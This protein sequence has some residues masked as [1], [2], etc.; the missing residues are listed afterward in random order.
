MAY[1]GL[2]AEEYDRKY[3]DRKL[4]KR[5]SKYFSPYRRSLIIV[6]IFLT[7]YSLSDSFVPILTRQAI[8][9][10]ET[11]LSITYLIFVLGLIFIINFLNWVFNYYRQIHAAK[12][13]GGVVLDLRRD[14]TSAVLNQDLSFFD[15]TPTG[16]IVSRINSDGQDFA[17][18]ADLTIEL[19]SSIIVLGFLITFMFSINIFLTLIFISS[20]PIFFIVALLFRKLARQK[21]LKGQRALANVNSY[22]KESISGI[23][24]A[25]TFRR[26]RKLYDRFNDVNQT[27][28]KVNLKR[29]WVLNTIFPTLGIVSGVIITL[30]IYFGGNGV[31]FG[32]IKG[33]DL[34][35][36]IQSIWLLRFPIFIISSFWPAFQAGLAAAERSFSLIDADP[37][38]IQEDDLK[39]SELRGKIEIKNLTFQYEKDKEV[40]KDFSL[41]VDPGE[42]VALVGH[43][44]AGKSSIA[45]LIARFYEFQN[46][47]I[48]IDNIDIRKFNLREYRKN[49]GI[50][51]QTPFLWADSIEKNIKYSRLTASREDVVEVLEKAGGFDWIEDL[52]EGLD[53]NIR[54]RGSLLSMGQRQLV[55]FARVLLEN[56]SILILDEAT[57]SVDPFTETRIQEAIEKIMENRTSIIIAHRLWTVRHVDRIIVLDHGKI[58]EEGSHDILMQKGGKYAELYKTYFRHQSIEYIDE[59]GRLET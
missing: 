40:F 54:E 53:T 56:P 14:A 2:D 43:T 41:S 29:A 10:I 9:N 11:N 4:L 23:Q 44:G 15:N 1:V 48:L 22:V 36:F 34:F 39:P 16:K 30:I 57:A 25:K 52:P 24:I 8:N 12:V 37:K 20:I 18:T 31:F 21:T 46:G 50:I 55:M 42:T 5:V 33:G 59:V 27:S 7:L 45:N 51:P 38:V 35:L 32:V 6:V 3:S 13:I 28:Y 58:V 17:R 19:L 47:E 49:L 26:E